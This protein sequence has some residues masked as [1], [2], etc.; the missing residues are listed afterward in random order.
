MANNLCTNKVEIINGKTSLEAYTASK[1]I[2]VDKNPG[3][4]PIGIGEVL[5][6]IIGKAIISTIKP[7]IMKS[8]G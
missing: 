5:R 7:E 8:A 2:P 6:C 3:V 1:L 4:R